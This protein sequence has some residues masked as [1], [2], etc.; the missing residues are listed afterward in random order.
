MR[1]PGKRTGAP[2]P[3][4]ERGHASHRFQ[5]V[6]WRDQPPDLVQPEPPER[7]TADLEMAGMSWIEGTPQNPHPAWD[8][9]RPRAA[10]RDEPD[11]SR[12]RHI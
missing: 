12:G 5:R 2:Q 11:P 10:A 9:E 1:V 6:L 8:E 7:R 3:L 4:F